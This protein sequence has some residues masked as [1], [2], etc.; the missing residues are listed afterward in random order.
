VDVSNEDVDALK[1]LVNVGVGMGSNTLNRMLSSHVRL[2]VPTLQVL[3]PEAVIV[4]LAKHHN[5]I[6]SSVCMPFK[7]NFS[8]AAHL[9]FPLDSAHNFVTALTGEEADGE[10]MDAIQAGT[11]SEIGNIVLNSVMGSIS[12]ALIVDLTYVVPNYLAGD[13]NI[14][15][16][17]HACSDTAVILFARTRFNI[18]ELEI[19]G[20]I[21]IFLEVGSF[22]KLLDA[23]RKYEQKMEI[24]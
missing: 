1:E 21:I 8:G 16:D 6:L 20:D 3:T 13:V 9:V 4:E 24:C 19:V 23:I 18:E 11:L 12:N 5:G 14:L 17:T 2:S 10:D 22:D 7:G 15:M